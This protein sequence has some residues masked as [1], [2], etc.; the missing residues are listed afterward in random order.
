M[1]E[2]E[3]EAA[4]AAFEE[5]KEE[6]LKKFDAN[7]D[8]KLDDTERAAARKAAEER[9]AEFIKKFDTDGDGKLSPAELRNA[10]EDAGKAPP[11]GNVPPEI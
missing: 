10:R 9:R 6:V 2:V 11:A 7:G 3:R 5:R 4:R 8:G 1:D